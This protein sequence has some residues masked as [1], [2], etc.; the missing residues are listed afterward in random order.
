MDSS[1]TEI[2]NALPNHLEFYHLGKVELQEFEHTWQETTAVAFRLY[3]ERMALVILLFDKDLDESVYSEFGNLLVSR[4]ATELSSKNGLEVTIS[5]PMK[6]NPS[7]LQ[8][9]IQR[10]TAIR[11]T[12]VHFHNNS[13]IPIE[14]WIL[15]TVVEEA[16]YA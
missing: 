15:P 10:V 12:Y 5:P 16:G 7:R 3:G 4:I 8:K 6:F 9:L 13:A 11:K 1:L 2:I 14:T